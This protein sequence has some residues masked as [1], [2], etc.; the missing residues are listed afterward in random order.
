MGQSGGTTGIRA[1]DLLAGLG[2]AVALARPE[3]AVVGETGRSEPY[4]AAPA[5]LAILR[6]E[7]QAEGPDS[8]FERCRP[9][10]PLG[11]VDDVWDRVARPVEA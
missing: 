5:W 2:H 3:M 9:F 10:V 7:R 1:C 4:K 8:A 11:Q 6:Y